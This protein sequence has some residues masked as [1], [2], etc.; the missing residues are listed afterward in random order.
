MKHSELSFS[1]LHHDQDELL[2]KEKVVGRSRARLLKKAEAR[3]E[4]KRR[5]DDPYYCGLSAR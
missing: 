3:A 1:L 4:E 2:V 5:N